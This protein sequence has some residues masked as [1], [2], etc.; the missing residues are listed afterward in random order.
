MF[1]EIYEGFGRA[2]ERGKKM[3]MSGPVLKQFDVFR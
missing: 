2:G 3:A 1:G